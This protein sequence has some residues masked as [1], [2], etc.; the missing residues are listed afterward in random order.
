VNK[1]QRAL[2]T[3]EHFGQ[4][5]SVFKILASGLVVS[6]LVVLVAGCGSLLVPP[7]APTSFQ[8]STLGLNTNDAPIV[9]YLKDA[10]AVNAALNPTATEA[11]I[12]LILTAFTTLAAAGAGWY[13]RHK[14][15]QV[16]QPSAK[17]TP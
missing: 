7:T 2:D 3:R 13:A 17:T 11:P 9:S 5:V 6:M 15:A 16:A 10:S 4:T 14:S 8:Q 1:N 12:A